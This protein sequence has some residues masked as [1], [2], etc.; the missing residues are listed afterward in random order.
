MKIAFHIGRANYFRPLGPLIDAALHDHEVE[1][2]VNETR[3]AQILKGNPPLSRESVPITGGQFAYR[4]YCDKATLR[5]ILESSPGTAIVDIAPLPYG[6]RKHV[7]ASS[8]FCYLQC[9][10][11]I[12]PDIMRPDFENLNPDLILFYSKHWQDTLTSILHD[13]RYG[14]FSDTLAMLTCSSAC[15][16]WGQMDQV[17]SF[18][19]ERILEK[20]DLPKDKPIVV[21]AAYPYASNPRTAWDFCYKHDNQLIRHLWGLAHGRLGRVLAHPDQTT[22]RRVAAA[23]RAFCARNDAVLII[24][25]RT[26]D[27][28]PGY[29]A[30]VAHRL[31]GDE[32][33]YPSNFME[34]LSVADLSL[35]FCSTSVLESSACG[36]PHICL[37][38]SEDPELR[39]RVPFF[40]S[41]WPRSDS[42]G[43]FNF[44]GVCYAMNIRDAVTELPHKSLD[45]FPL[46]SRQHEQY[47][48]DYLGSTD[49]GNCARILEAIRLHRERTLPRDAESS[50]EA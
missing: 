28:V 37:D 42:Q 47:C 16:G 45:D 30:E 32:S 20:Y 1:L 9:G 13:R 34:V 22:D 4:P 27:P 41:F 36:C 43:I 11:D 8:T 26:K 23:L 48:R 15:V 21:L 17:V 49:G 31:I 18:D 10:M 6:L 35:S 5:D 25:Y 50:G 29:F 3:D 39:A 2:W 7:P 14:N 38:I 24:K 44:P 46:L 40:E 12:I 33:H 19:R